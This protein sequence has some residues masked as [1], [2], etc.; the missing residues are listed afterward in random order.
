MTPQEILAKFRMKGAGCCTEGCI[1][2]QKVL[3]MLEWQVESVNKLKRLILLVDDAVSSDEMN[4][5]S[6]K[7]W[8]EYERWECAR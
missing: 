5:L 7:Q 3:Q 8:A 6:A 1:P 2:E 4:T